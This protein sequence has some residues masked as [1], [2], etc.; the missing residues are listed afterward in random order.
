MRNKTQERIEE[1]AR[2]RRAE[3]SGEGG[4]IDLALVEEGIEIGKAMM[5]EMISTYTSQSRSP[6]VATAA[7]VAP[8]PSAAASG[9]PAPEVPG[10][11]GGGYLNEVRSLSAAARKD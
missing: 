1:L 10:A 3:A 8:E 4:A 11:T 5:A 9:A 7:P 6:G 2:E